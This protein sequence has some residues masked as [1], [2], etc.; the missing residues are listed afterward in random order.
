MSKSSKWY[1]T[2]FDGLYGRVLAGQFD[3]DKS[4][5][6]ART[7][8]RALRLRK[9]RRVLDCPCG[10][11]RISL[12]LARLGLD[13]TGAD[14]NATFVRSAR[15]RAA[16]AGLAIPFVRCDMRELPFEGEFDAAVNWFTSIGYFDDAGNLAAARAAFA[17]LKLG[18]KFLI[19]A[20]NKSWLLAHWRG[21]GEKVINGVRVV[22]RPRW[23]AATNRVMCAWTLTHGGRAERR[24]IVLR[25]YNGAEIRALLRQAGFRDI[26]LFGRPPLGRLTRHSRRFIA[27]GT[28]PRK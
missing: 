25:V 24:H 28:R 1:E 23:D 13:V 16:S 7:I 11:G 6:Q 3:G 9:G 8:K 21:R 22:D 10:M 18:G 12:E 5:A 2:F 4:A 27:I 20:M 26:R 17:A 19:E 14:L 15:S